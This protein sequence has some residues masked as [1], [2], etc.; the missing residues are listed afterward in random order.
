MP[1]YPLKHSIAGELVHNQSWL[2]TTWLFAGIG[3]YAPYKVGIRV[4]EGA[5]QGSQVNQE[6]AGHSLPT[7]SFF[8]LASSFRL[9]RFRK[10]LPGVVSPDVHEQGACASLHDVHHSVIHRVLV[11]LKPP[12]D[13]VADSS[14][15]VDHSKVSIGVS[16][17][18]G[19]GKSGTLAKQ[20]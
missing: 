8:L 12:S 16:F 4:I 1:P 19:F 20:R 17:R 2:H 7:C 18:H 5:H 15:I 10:S 9:L 3:Y 13:I 6:H 14:S 11:F